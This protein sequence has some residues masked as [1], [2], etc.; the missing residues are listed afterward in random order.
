[1]RK[2]DFL[3]G[4]KRC[5]VCKNTYPLTEEYF[6]RSKRIKDGFRGQCKKCR[7]EKEYL[8]NKEKILKKNK[9][10]YEENKERILAQQNEYYNK[11]KEYY[12]EYNSKYY[13]KNKDTIKKQAS[14]Y[15]HD[16]KESLVK[17]M[18]INSAIWWSTPKGKAKRKEYKQVRRAREHS[19]PSS[20]TAK[21][22]NATLKHF[23]YSCAYC[24]EE[25]S[26]LQI[27]HIIPVSQ[28]GGF[29]KQNIIPACPSCNMSKNT[30]HMENWYRKQDFFSQTQLEKIWELMKVNPKNKIQQLNIL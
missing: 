19:A 30:R 4:A 10:R 2:T 7:R 13:K 15:Y 27:E 1:M 9:K 28:G 23:N 3:E 18:R 14:K 25:T 5:S 26:E 6:G 8:P 21:E 24:L 12:Q 29:T 17:R 22:W 20:L 16:N 11:N